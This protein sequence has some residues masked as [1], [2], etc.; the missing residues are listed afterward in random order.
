MKKKSR[1]KKIIK[2][3]ALSLAGLI[4]VTLITAGFILYGRIASMMSIR[5][6]RQGSRTT[7]NC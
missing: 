3:A 1:A 2:I 4:L 7:K 5:R 6:W